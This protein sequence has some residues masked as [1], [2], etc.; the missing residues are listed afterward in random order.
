[1]QPVTTRLGISSHQMED[2]FCIW[3]TVGVAWEVEFTDEFRDWWNA[4][5][6]EQQ[7]D[8]AH[9]VRHLIEFGPAL[10]FPH[11]S[12]VGSS[13][14]PQDAGV[15]DSERWEA[16][17]DTLRIQ[18]A[19]L[20]NSLDRGREDRSAHP[21]AHASAACA[22]PSAMLRLDM[23][24]GMKRIALPRTCFG[25]AEVA[26][27]YVRTRSAAPALDGLHDSTTP[28]ARA[29]DRLRSGSLP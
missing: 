23:Y 4:L 15:A 22:G 9:S 8:V 6:G 3:H 21:R 28:P 26:T 1:M 11:S 24:R 5:S 10:G 12:K 19:P 17:S 27:S 18:P 14:Y 20:G 13:R 16:A 2:V 7:D 29:P 25:P